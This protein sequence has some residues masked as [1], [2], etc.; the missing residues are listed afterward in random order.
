MPEGMEAMLVRAS[1]FLKGTW[2]LIQL[3]VP[4]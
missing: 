2:Q 4:M 1:V 3:E